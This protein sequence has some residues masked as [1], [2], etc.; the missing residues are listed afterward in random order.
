[1][2]ALGMSVARL[3]AGGVVRAKWFHASVLLSLGLVGFF[4][5][6]ATRESQ[7]VGFT[8]Y[9]RVM[10]GVVQ[11]SLLFLPLLSIFSTSQAIPSSRQQGVLEWYLVHPLSRGNC[12]FG[13]FLPRVLA[14]SLPALGA[15]LLLGAAAAWTGE[16]LSSSLLL[17]YSLLLAGQ[18]FCFAS[19]GMAVGAM[20]RSPEQALL[21]GLT[22][23]TASAALVD[24]V[25]LGV[26]L[27]WSLPP[28]MVFGLAVINPLQSGRVGMLAGID[29]DLSVLGPVGTWAVSTL[30][31]NFT[32]AY[33]LLWPVVLGAMALGVARAVFV[34]RDVL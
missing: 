10:A 5:L 6:V 31:A 15:A 7:V 29:P 18:A 16:G 33:G 19:L 11:A 21:L 17:E 20:A 2:N 9:G 32:L 14:A 24:F 3:E 13:L 22:V 28:Q 8:G 30:G 23:W 25:L 26:M 4:V 27:R 12:F 1:M 34:R